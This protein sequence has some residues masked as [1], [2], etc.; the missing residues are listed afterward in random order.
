MR[1]VRHSPH[2]QPGPEEAGP[3]TAPGP[4]AEQS[5][6]AATLGATL[7]VTPGS[8]QPFLGDKSDTQRA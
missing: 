1:N 5:P 4:L 2:E 3:G 7:A 8:S 6:P